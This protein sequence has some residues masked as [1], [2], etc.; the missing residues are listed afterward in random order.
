MAIVY[1]KK[2]KIRLFKNEE[3]NPEDLTLKELRI[4][5]PR[6]IVEKIEKWCPYN[7]SE[8]TGYKKNINKH[9]SKNSSQFLLNFLIESDL[10]EFSIKNLISKL[11][12]NNLTDGSLQ[13]VIL[14]LLVCKG[15]I[16]KHKIEFSDKKGKLKFKMVYSVNE[17]QIPCPYLNKKGRCIF[18]WRIARESRHFTE[19]T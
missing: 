1:K 11:N 14:S 19:G 6:A 18:N 10:K 8:T 2:E 13:R 4:F 16:K 9:L 3:K 17:N 5:P 7:N 15:I 12:A